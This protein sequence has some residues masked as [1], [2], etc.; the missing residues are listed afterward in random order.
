MKKYIRIAFLLMLCSSNI[1]TAQNI[2]AAYSEV[3]IEVNNYSPEKQL[4]LIQSTL[5]DYAPNVTVNYACTRSGWLLFQMSAGPIQNVDQLADVLKQAGFLF[6]VKENAGL[7]E[8]IEV[9]QEPL[10]NL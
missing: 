3:L 7:S 8:L 1:S 10:Q 6:I 5:S 2:N 9:C 4:S